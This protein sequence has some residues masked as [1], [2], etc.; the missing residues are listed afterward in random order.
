MNQVVVIDAKRSP[1]GRIPGELNFIEET[2]LLS[3]VFVSMKKTWEKTSVDEAV[4]GSSFP[5]ERDNLCRKAVQNI[6]GLDAVPAYT[7]S[8]TCA[9]SDEALRTAF[10]RIKAGE[11]QVMLVGGC[12]KVSNSPYTLHFMKKNVKKAMRGQLPKYCEISHGIEENDMVYINEMLSRKHQ[13][14][15]AQQDDFTVNSI[16]KAYT[17][18]KKGFFRTEIVPIEYQVGETSHS[19]AWDEWIGND[20]PEHHIREAA[21]MFL[22][23]GMITQYNA[24][25]MCECAAAMLLANDTYAMRQKIPVLAVL[26]DAITIG[27]D[28]EERGNTMARCVDRLLKRNHFMASDIDLFEINESFACQAIHTMRQLGIEERKVNVNGGNLALGYPIGA[29]GLRMSISLIYEMIRRGVRWGISVM[30]SGGN[31]ANAALFENPFE[32]LLL[33][34]PT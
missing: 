13:I 32:I 30:C 29:T 34:E 21:P 11:A 12:E 19:L 6:D 18:E 1:V 33:D 27:V 10:S 20:R 3:R 4:T 2:L 9:S 14:S 25:P 26:K 28:R 5:I 31:M 17:A 22:E 24:A 23:D 8:K 16:K 15:R 7:L